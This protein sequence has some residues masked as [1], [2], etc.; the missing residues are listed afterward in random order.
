MFELAVIEPVRRGS[1]ERVAVGGWGEGKGRGCSSSMVKLRGGP[2]VQPPF[3][4]SMRSAFAGRDT[5]A[6]RSRG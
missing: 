1:C 4:S 5:S 6:K 2:L 3:A